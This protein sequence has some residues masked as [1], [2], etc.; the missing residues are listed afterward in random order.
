MSFEV[1]EACNRINEIYLDKFSRMSFNTMVNTYILG[2]ELRIDYFYYYIFAKIGI[3]QLLPAFNV[4]VV[5][6]CVFYII[7]RATQIFKIN[8]RTVI[9]AIFIIM[10][11]GSPP[12]AVI[13]A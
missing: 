4:A 2:G 10:A 5:Y 3:K 13:S 12:A 8:R 11:V 1:N 6:S 9:I 7:N